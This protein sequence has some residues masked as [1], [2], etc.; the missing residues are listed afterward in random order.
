MSSI[1]PWRDIV[2]RQSRQ[3]MVGTVPVGGDAPITVQTMTNT[4]T[5]DVKATVEQIQAAERAGADIVRVSCPDEESSAALREIVPQVTVPV[6]RPP[7][8]VTPRWSG[9]SVASASWW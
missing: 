4:L 9:A 1:R 5:P 2:R 6:L 3:I 7:A 8:S